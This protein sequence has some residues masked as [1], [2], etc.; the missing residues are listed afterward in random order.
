ME[1]LF[2]G[3]SIQTTM[4]LQKGRHRRSLSVDEEP[5]SIEN[6]SSGTSSPR[7]SE[8][9]S[10]V[11]LLG[12]K[13]MKRTRSSFGSDED[14][15]EGLELYGAS[16]PTSLVERIS[17]SSI[18]I[19]G[20]RRVGSGSVT[21]NAA[22]SPWPKGICTPTKGMESK[23]A[24]A[25]TTASLF[26]SPTKFEQ[27]LKISRMPRR[28]MSDADGT[29]HC[30]DAF[31][32]QK[33]QDFENTVDSRFHK[34][35]AHESEIGSQRKSCFALPN[36]K[37]ED[38]DAC[39]VSSDT[40][41][42]I[43][44]ENPSTGL[45][46]SAV[47]SWPVENLNMDAAYLPVCDVC[48]T[49]FETTD[50]SFTEQSAT[51]SLNMD[52]DLQGIA[53]MSSFPDSNST[54]LPSLSKPN[55]LDAACEEPLHLELQNGK[56]LSIHSESSDQIIYYK[57]NQE[58]TLAL[59]SQTKDFICT[60]EN[61]T[62]QSTQPISSSDE[63]AKAKL[64]ETAFQSCLVGEMVPVSPVLLLEESK[65]IDTVGSQR[66]GGEIS[67]CWEKDVTLSTDFNSSDA[68]LSKRS[69]SG[70]GDDA[71][72]ET[73]R[74]K[75]PKRRRSG[76]ASGLGD[77]VVKVIRVTESESI[78][79]RALT[80]LAPEVSWIDSTRS[81]DQFEPTPLTETNFSTEAVDM[82]VDCENCS[83]EPLAP[84]TD[85]EK[86]G[87]NA[88]GSSDYKD[89]KQTSKQVVGESKHFAEGGESDS[90]LRDSSSC[91]V[92]SDEYAKREVPSEKV[93]I[94][95]PRSA[96]EKGFA[97]ITTDDLNVLKPQSER[98]LDARD[99]SLGGI[100]SRRTEACCGSEQESEEANLI[101]KI[102]NQEAVTEN[103]SLNV[104]RVSNVEENSGGNQRKSS[105]GCAGSISH[106]L[107]SS[108]ELQV[109][110]VGDMFEASIG[111]ENIVKQPLSLLEEN[112]CIL[113]RK[114]PRS[115]SSILQVSP[116]QS[117]DEYRLPPSS[118]TILT[119]PSFSSSHQDRLWEEQAE[120]YSSGG[121]GTPGREFDAFA[122]VNEFNFHSLSSS[123]ACISCI[124][125][126]DQLYCV[127][128][129]LRKG[130]AK[131]RCAR[132]A[133]SSFVSDNVQCSN[134]RRKLGLW[135]RRGKPQTPLQTLLVEGLHS[136]ASSVSGHRSPDS[137]HHFLHHLMSRIRGSRSSS[138]SSS[139][140]SSVAVSK[141]RNTIW[142]SCICFSRAQ[143]VTV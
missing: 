16:L 75:L 31:E 99:L 120:A 106:D 71:R 6:L 123:G 87:A 38:D 112:E 63:G 26:H 97:L 14:V 15:H 53:C 109:K 11:I 143:L 110:N 56:I 102:D 28:L 96:N 94:C 9:N 55:E 86:E 2:S 62:N 119:N 54:N 95:V 21:H 68:C 136:R 37:M 126:D 47:D 70:P 4:L 85:T 137:S 57:D 113:T 18:S 3:S 124:S 142:S 101:V 7:T 66:E 61:E 132:S 43:F 117:V 39:R 80:I 105:L 135:K 121:L 44:T 79:E 131:D 82:E 8:K 69:G 41:S 64:T 138:K 104:H 1:R 72:T 118:I 36:K 129:S 42:M 140:R 58:V 32:E 93:I 29:P 111:A 5:N 40:V 50:T 48:P 74:T 73:K 35:V 92:T 76:S 33:R 98:F 108:T 130:H 23:H 127:A 125:S 114:Q 10:A 12:V 77:M 22:G 84:D 78:K 27:P 128:A 100:P 103:A 46:G 88:G 65:G 107:N 122:V 60:Q 49:E 134:G 115:S 89:A 52:H 20:H 17:L 34:E 141:K 139:P 19:R 90:V 45:L 83:T 91:G 116:R 67:P 30:R 51:S 24:V 13:K 81:T 133:T 25:M 59:T